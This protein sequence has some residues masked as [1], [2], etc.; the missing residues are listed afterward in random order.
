MTLL[1]ELVLRF[2]PYTQGQ[3][4]MGSPNDPKE[5]RVASADV[6]AS[7]SAKSIG[8]SLDPC[9]PAAPSHRDQQNGV[10]TNKNGQPGARGSTYRFV[11]K[12]QYTKSVLKT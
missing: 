12:S 5:V 3:G 10:S 1:P 8:I 11:I 9:N 7:M 6:S 4:N 2:P